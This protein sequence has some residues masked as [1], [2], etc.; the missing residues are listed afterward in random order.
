MSKKIKKCQNK[1]KSVTKSKI[2][3][4]KICGKICQ[5][6]RTWEKN[7]KQMSIGKCIFSKPDYDQIIHFIQKI[8]AKHRLNVPWA[9][10]NISKMSSKNV[11]FS[12]KNDL[13]DMTRLPL[14]LI[15]QQCFDK[16]YLVKMQLHIFMNI[17]Y[18]T[19]FV[20][21][22]TKSIQNWQKG[23]HRLSTSHGR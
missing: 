9:S 14:Q 4:K 2:V 6:V 15:P 19:L 11:I 21:A 13:H 22:H 18:R 20:R 3:K 7:V 16:R 10:Q 17:P 23:G 5:K 12:S 8:M 1:L